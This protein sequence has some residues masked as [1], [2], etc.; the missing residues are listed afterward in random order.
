MKRYIQ[1][2]LILGVTVG[3]M[4]F[5]LRNAELDLIGDAFRQARL[6]LL[7]ASVSISI[8][9][10]G[11]RV[12]R[13]RWLLRPLVGVGFTTA[14]RATVMGFAANTL[15]PGRVGEVLRPMVLARHAPI[16]TSAGLATIVVERVLDLLAIVIMLAIAVLLFHPPMSD[17]DMF[18]TLRLAAVLSGT[19]GVIGSAAL[20]FVAQNPAQA[21]RGVAWAVR[22][23]PF[24]ARR[25]V[26]ELSERFFSGL[27]VVRQPRT[28]VVAMG[29]SIVLWLGIASGI[30]AATVAFGIEVS[31]A[32]AVVLTGLIALGVSVPT[33]GGAG[34]YHAAFQLGAT[35]LYGASAGQAVA[36]G[37]INHAIAFV[38]VT[39]VGVVLM[40][41]EG[42]RM[43]T[44]FALSDTPAPS[45]EISRS[46]S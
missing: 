29:L 43:N 36:A 3:L 23:L 14:G 21:M 39:L 40:A 27:A 42:I 18:S 26:L 35:A 19:V 8:L 22:I 16:S 7:G 9:T 45:P 2:V 46:S 17:V 15:L 24:R 13:W 34:G 10:Y 12:E 37:L 25:V 44:V 41:Q 1:T 31:V 38:P 33:P 28:L 5:F 32:G 20:V 6:G 4:A 11:I 30:W